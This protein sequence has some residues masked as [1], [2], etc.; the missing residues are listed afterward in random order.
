MYDV[1]LRT[2]KMPFVLDMGETFTTSN[3]L[4]PNRLL[5]F[6]VF[7]YI[8]KGRMQVIEEEREYWLHEG[9]VLL[10]KKGLHHWG[11]VSALA[12]TKTFWIH[13]DTEDEKSHFK[14]SSF[15]TK[16]S[17]AQELFKRED[18]CSIL[19]LP[20]KLTIQNRTFVERK[21]S[22]M[23]WTFRSREILKH[24]TT[25]A[26]TME[27]FLIIYRQQVLES[28]SSN[29]NRIVQKVKEYV[30]S[31]YNERLNVEMLS[32]ELQLTYNYI[33]TVFK[34]NTGFSISSYHERMRII[35]ST[36]LMKN[37][38]MNISQ[39]S[40]KVGYEDP[41]YFSRVFKKVTGYSPS[42]Y[43]NQIY[44]IDL[45]LKGYISE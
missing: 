38:N 8:Y 17:E 13:F 24:L 39:I 23:L 10:L 22:D 25:A 18:Y 26:L 9:D 21:I 16:I 29:S 30:E 12:G 27:F 41:L 3:W 1:E 40:Q 35:R 44:R 37:S 20:K 4:H 34:G 11:T 42:T 31:H 43:L 2:E 15:M 45:N 5:D 19:V 32:D 14:L 6:H 7:I 36:E 28:C 33:S